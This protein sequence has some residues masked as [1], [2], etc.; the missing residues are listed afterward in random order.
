M[1]QASIDHIT[2]VFH[3]NIQGKIIQGHA[4]GC[5]NYGRSIQYLINGTHGDNKKQA[6][7]NGVEIKTCIGNAQI[8]LPTNIMLRGVAN[9]NDLVHRYGEDGRLYQ[10][11]YYRKFCESDIYKNSL[12]WER[13]GDNLRIVCKKQNGDVETTDLYITIK[14]VTDC[15]EKMKNLCVFK[16]KKKEG[17]VEFHKVYFHSKL[18][19]DNVFKM[20]ELDFIF[21]ELK[22]RL[23]KNHGCGFRILPS[24]MDKIY[25]TV[26]LVK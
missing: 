7:Y 19:M 14:D 26:S 4:G 25:D 10:K 13:D 20:I 2:K 5:G 18:S 1:I 22:M 8:T 12:K 15:M 9:F 3:E 6:D 17:G 21:Y 24:Y 23:G 16:G 11:I